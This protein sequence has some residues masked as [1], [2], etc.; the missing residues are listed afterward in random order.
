MIVAGGQSRNAGR[1]CTLDGRGS[2]TAANLG[3]RLGRI[4]KLRRAFEI[5]KDIVSKVV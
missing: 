5:T 2:P 1:A 3:A 4:V